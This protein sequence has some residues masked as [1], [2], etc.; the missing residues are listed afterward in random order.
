MSTIRVTDTNNSVYLYD[1]DSGLSAGMPIVTK[2]YTLEELYQVFAET[3]AKYRLAKS[4]CKCV[5]EEIT[6]YCMSHSLRHVDE[7]PQ[8]L[9]AL[10]QK[11]D[12]LSD[13]MYLYETALHGIRGAIK[14]Y[15]ALALNK[16]IAEVLPRYTGKQAGPKTTKKFWEEV[17]MRLP[18]KPL[19]YR[20]YYYSITLYDEVTR[21]ENNF[22]YN[23]GLTTAG[24]QFEAQFILNVPSDAFEGKYPRDWLVW[25]THVNKANSSIREYFETFFKYMTSLQ[26]SLTIGDTPMLSV[27]QFDLKEK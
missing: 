16:A 18:N 24:N 23:D 7:L 14:Y 4:R 10:E 19:V 17:S 9:V 1:N 25:A 13:D 2:V 27:S 6:T 26:N 11:R 5:A 3:S 22:Y 20:M 8:E 15:Q 12:S 21:I